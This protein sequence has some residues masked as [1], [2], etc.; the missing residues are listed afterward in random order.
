MTLMAMEASVSL[1]SF[2]FATLTVINLR[3]KNL[4]QG[5]AVTLAKKIMQS[6][7]LKRK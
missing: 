5:T 7:F 6:S 3:N 1:I 2:F 4:N